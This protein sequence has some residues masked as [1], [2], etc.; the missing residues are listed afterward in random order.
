MQ[1]RLTLVVKLLNQVLSLYVQVPKFI[2]VCLTMFFC[3][4]KYPSVNEHKASCLTDVRCAET[5]LKA[6]KGEVER[7]VKRPRRQIMPYACRG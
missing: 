7:P 4:R 2:L 1:G 6:V 3:L 5:R